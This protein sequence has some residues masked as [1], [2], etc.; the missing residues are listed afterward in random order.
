M[1]KIVI[2][3]IFTFIISF[4]LFL[5]VQSY[6]PDKQIIKEQKFYSNDFNSQDKIIFLMGSSSVGQLNSTLIDETISQK[7]TK[8]TVYNLSY[9]GDTPSERIKTVDKVIKLNPKIVL[10]GISYRDFQVKQIEHQPLP[11][12]QQ[13]FN[14]LFTN[15]IGFNNEVNPKL[16]TLEIIRKSF[17]NTGLFPTR[18]LIELHNSPFFA[19]TSESTIIANEMELKQQRDNLVKNNLIN[20]DSTLENKQ[21]KDL[22]K[23]IEKFQKNKIKIIVFYTPM[24]EYYLEQISP[25]TK[26]KFSSILEKIRNNYDIKIY[27]FTDKYVNEDIWANITHVAYNKNATIYS[28]DIAKIILDEIES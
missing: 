22:N 9:N 25:E 28:V 20:I 10:Y 23:I 11:D 4:G 3:V 13:F 21:I 27:D 24:H 18:E 7:F 19:F 6:F 5:I 17:S 26:T 12:P 16:I 1:K 15:E 14:N 8:Y 2:V